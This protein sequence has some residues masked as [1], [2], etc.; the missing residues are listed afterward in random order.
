MKMSEQQTEMEL[1]C[2]GV[3]FTYNENFTL[4]NY[5]YFNN[6]TEDEMIARSKSGPTYVAI[7]Y[8]NGDGNYVF[9][10]YMN[11]N[12]IYQLYDEGAVSLLHGILEH[13][14]NHI[15]QDVNVNILKLEQPTDE[16]ISDIIPV[17]DIT[18]LISNVRDTRGFLLLR[19]A[20]ERPSSRLI[21]FTSTTQGLG[22]NFDVHGPYGMDSLEIY[23]FGD[24]GYVTRLTR[25]YDSFSSLTFSKNTPDSSKIITTISNKPFTIGDLPDIIK[26]FTWT[27]LFG[28]T[29]NHKGL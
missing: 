10:V 1:M 14:N 16:I 13:M 9:N 17:P 8:D 27:Y 3:I 18:Y 7:R 19:D 29:R 20:F 5:E 2:E 15:I 25:I 22:V 24:F 12:R 23:N 21:S 4:A 28:V 11:G 6:A 26:D